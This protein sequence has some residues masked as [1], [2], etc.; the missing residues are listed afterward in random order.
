MPRAVAV[1]TGA[2][3]GL[4]LAL[5]RGLCRQWGPEGIVYLTA[6]D[7][8]KGR[9]AVESL[10]EEGLHPRFQRLDLTDSAS[11]Q[12]MAD[13]VRDEHG[14]L[15]LLIQNGAYAAKPDLPGQAQARL[16]IDTNNFGTHRVLRAFRSMLRPQARV[17][18][19]ASGFGTLNSLDPRV[20]DR[21][22]TDRLD[23][24][25]LERNL[26]AY[27]EAVEQGRAQDQGWPDWVNIPSKVGQVAAARIFAREWSAD[28]ATPPGVLINAVCPGWMITDASRPYLHQLPPDVTPQ[29]PDEAAPDVLWVG[30][31]PPGTTGPQ[32]ELIQFRQILPWK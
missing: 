11:V 25:G 21:F 30:L 16:M 5:V 13:R 31:L 4:G 9:R 32:G 28:P 14:G 3:K 15:D 10:E 20:H 12:A 26:S 29:Q 17:L 24:A 22:D 6:R 2:N 7:P 23:L 1:I 27:V 8:D 19:A 18:V